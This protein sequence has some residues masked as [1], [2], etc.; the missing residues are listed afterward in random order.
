MAALNLGLDLR[1]NLVNRICL[2]FLI[3]SASV[4]LNI[5]LNIVMKKKSVFIEVIL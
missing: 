4:E 2:L 1:K 3:Q 5:L